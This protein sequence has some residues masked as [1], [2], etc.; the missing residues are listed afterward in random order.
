MAKLSAVFS[1][2]L[3]TLS[4][5]QRSIRLGGQLLSVSYLFLILK[6][7]T[8]NEVPGQLAITS[9]SVKVL[10]CLI[11]KMFKPRRQTAQYRHTKNFV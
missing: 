5:D 9:E 4:R 10:K 7:S 3:T 11:V 2:L 8:F 1:V 6:Q